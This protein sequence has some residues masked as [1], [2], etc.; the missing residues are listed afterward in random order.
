MRLLPPLPWLLVAATVAARPLTEAH[1]SSLNCTAFCKYYVECLCGSPIPAKDQCLSCIAKSYANF[2]DPKVVS[3]PCGWS[4]AVSICGGTP[5][6]PP[7][8]APPPPPPLPPPFPPNIKQ[9]YH[10]STTQG[11]D[12]NDGSAA[13]PFKTIQKC[14]DVSQAQAEGTECSILRGTYRESVAFSATSKTNPS[15]FRA[16]SVTDT[17][18]VISGLDV[19][20]NHDWTVYKGAIYKTQLHLSASN[21]P[22]ELEQLFMNGVMMIEARWPNVGDPVKDFPL[23]ML[24]PTKWE[25]TGSHRSK[26]RKI[27]LVLQ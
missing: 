17:P 19:V 1:T 5:P 18:P 16:A 2:S 13:H 25:T 24:D 21:T 27:A 7:T 10:V 6:G 11:S 12:S 4:R 23:N 8:P 3:I 15:L 20:T 9:H 22:F 26:L 14:A